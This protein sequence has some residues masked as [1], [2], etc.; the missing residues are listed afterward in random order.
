MCGIVGV[1]G[2]RPAAPLLLDAL[3]R[4]EYRGYDSAGIATLVAGRIERRRA[5]GKL[6][7]LA[8]RLEAEP[9]GGR[10][11][12]RPHP[13]GHARRAQRDQRPSRMSATAWRWSTTASSRTS[14]SCAPS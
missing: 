6:D 10:H 8:E 5:P 7:R 12:H 1:I 2:G 3:R 9:L 13:L 14:W 11:R 4:L